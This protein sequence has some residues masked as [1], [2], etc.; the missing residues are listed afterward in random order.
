MTT[1]TTLSTHAFPSAAQ[2]SMPSVVP[3]WAAVGVLSV[4]VVALGSSLIQVKQRSTEP[5]AAMAQTASPAML[6]ATASP[7]AMITEKADG[8]PITKTPVSKAPEKVKTQAVAKPA[9]KT[10][11][12]QRFSPPANAP[13]VV[14][15]A[16]APQAVCASC[17]T[18]EA[19]TPVTREG[20]GSGVG[21]IAGGLIGGVLGNQVGKGNGRK[22]ATVLGAVG[23]GWAGNKIEKNMKTTTAYAVRVRMEDGS[24]RTI[25][26][27]TAPAV[28]TKVTVEGGAL[29]PA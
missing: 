13:V 6:N 16:P 25:E 18:V 4:C 2:S 28:G 15:Q 7:Q 12:V 19:V 14:S 11:V 10:P 17:G 21:V 8:T 26:Q 22:A 5:L 3:L 1:A 27:S 23:G 24:R 20:Q 29:T 9:V